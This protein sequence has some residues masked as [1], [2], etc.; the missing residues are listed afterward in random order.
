MKV[1]RLIQIIN[2]EQMEISMCKSKLYGETA[3]SAFLQMIHSPRW[4]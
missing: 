2:K 3:M 4:G 1:S